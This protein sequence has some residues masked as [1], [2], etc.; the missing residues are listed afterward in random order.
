M[1]RT[2]KI[3]RLF[4]FGLLLASL[5]SCQSTK[6]SSANL[7]PAPAD[8]Q[9]FGRTVRPVLEHRCI[10]CH[11]NEK[12]NAGLN[13]QNPS[14]LYTLTET[15]RFIDPGSP[16]TSRIYMAIIKP[17]TH[18]GAMPGDGWGIDLEDLQG[19]RTW[20][21]DGAPWPEGKN[22]QL[23]VKDYQVKLDDYP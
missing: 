8:P 18:P 20:I 17:N 5:V 21:K 16:E 14:L 4:P 10:H 7:P 6:R 23:E 11:N 15:G 13:F 12:P 2:L 9:V 1:N 22:G 19:F 3:Y